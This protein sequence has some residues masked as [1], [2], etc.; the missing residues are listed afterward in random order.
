MWFTCPTRS[1]GIH[2]DDAVCLLTKKWRKWT[3]FRDLSRYFTLKARVRW[4]CM[5]REL[6]KTFNIAHH[7]QYQC[8]LHGQPDLQAYIM[9]TQCVYPRKSNENG[10][11]QDLSRYFTLKARARRLC[12]LRELFRNLNNAHHNQYQGGLHNQSFPQTYTMK[13]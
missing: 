7:N 9:M 8:D 6:C 11:F 12:I 3:F 10:R 13:L 2:R 4:L 1:T 5:L